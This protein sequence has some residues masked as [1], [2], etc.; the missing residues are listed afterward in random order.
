MKTPATLILI[1]ALMAS[2]GVAHAG[3][4][5]IEIAGGIKPGDTLMVAL[6]DSEAHWLEKSTRG[7]KQSAPADLGD[8]GTHTLRVDALAPGRYAVAVYVDRNGNG[9][10]DRGMF[11]RPTE[12][13]GFS[14]GGGSFGPPDFVD[15]LIEVADTGSAIRIDLN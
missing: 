2:G 12:P 10:L 3:S 13:Y 5:A 4:L 14:N 9:K 7:I 15:A 6:Y 11:G 1:S 8:H